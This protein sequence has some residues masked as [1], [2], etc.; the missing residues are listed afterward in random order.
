MK[1]GALVVLGVAAAF[2]VAHAQTTET[3]AY[4]NFPFCQCIK[5][6][7]P[8]SIVPTVK[9]PSK[10]TYCFTLKVTKPSPSATGYCATQADVFKIE[11]NVFKSCDVYGPVVNATLNGKPTKV[12]P[13]FDAPAQ[14]PAD[15]MILRLTQLDLG[16]NSDGAE[17][18]L[19]LGLNERGRGCATLEDLCVPPAGA[20]RGTCSIAM[21]DYK[22]NCCPISKPSP[23]SPPPPPPPPPSL[24]PTTPPP[25]TVVPIAPCKTCIYLTVQEVT[26]QLWPFVFSSDTCK[27]L[28]SEAI[29]LVEQAASLAGAGLISDLTTYTCQDTV[30]KI[31]FGFYTPDRLQDSISDILAAIRDLVAPTCPA[32]LN[33]YTIEVFVSE[34]GIDPFGDPLESCL[35]GT[36]VTMCAPEKVDFPKCF[37]E[38]KAF[39]TRFAAQPYLTSAPGRPTPKVNT[40]LYCFTLAVVEPSPANTYC[41]NTTVLLKAEIWG[42]D[43]PLQRRK[44]IALAFQEAGSDTLKYISPSWGATGDQTLK[45]SPLNWSAE[46]AD[47]AKICLELSN[48]TD[49]ETFCNH[50]DKTCWIN[51]FSPTK[52]CC[53]VFPASVLP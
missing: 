16:L 25:D 20:N 22:T 15:A 11:F 3:A 47:G 38:T 17:L 50:G 32:Y 53:P 35:S 14:G 4:P 45:V 5:T 9:N 36:I 46:K 13:N 26:P 51:L 12:G 49:L 42:N 18:C 48:A 34:D 19:S 8:Y 31:C 10:G 52:E 39:A 23:P 44:I 40:T 29:A 27:L 21:F 28:V 41:A 30:I 33:G 24:P 1:F 7:S 2:A 6:P 43:A 37:C